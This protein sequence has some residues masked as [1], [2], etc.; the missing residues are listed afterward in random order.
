MIDPKTSSVLIVVL[1]LLLKQ[2]LNQNYFKTNI[3][4]FSEDHFCIILVCS[5]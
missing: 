3:F 4:P 2:Q 5:L 1:E